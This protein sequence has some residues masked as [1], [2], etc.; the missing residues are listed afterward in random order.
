MDAVQV[1]MYD[2]RKLEELFQEVEVLDQRSMVRKA[3][4]TIMISDELAEHTALE[5]T[6]F[7]PALAH[8]AGEDSCVAEV[9]EEHH[10]IQ[11]VLLELAGMTPLDSTFHPKLKVLI[12]LV[13]SHFRHEEDQLLPAAQQILSSQRLNEL[14]AQMLAR[15][16]NDA[17]VRHV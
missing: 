3:E 6:Y 9:N 14:G 17:D 1:L 16:E 13:R 5:E 4:L 11:I 8:E 10:I 12:D 15:R 2:H 7:F